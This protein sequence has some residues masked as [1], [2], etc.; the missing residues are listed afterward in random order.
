MISLERFVET[1][2]RMLAHLV[3]E[4]LMLLA[5]MESDL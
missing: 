5:D 4:I 3:D 2:C 1:N